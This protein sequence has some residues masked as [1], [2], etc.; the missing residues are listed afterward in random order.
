MLTS[1]PS[2]CY[3]HLFHSA[4]FAFLL[5]GRRT[6]AYLFWAV[7]ALLNGIFNLFWLTCEID[8]FCP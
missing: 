7:F 6:E 5:V 2:E 3:W 8:S 1:M 4:I